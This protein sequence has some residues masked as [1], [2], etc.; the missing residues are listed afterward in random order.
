METWKDIPGFEGSYQVSDLGNVRSL[1]R[2]V[3]T[4]AHGVEAVRVMSG[5][6]LRS[7]DCRG[8]RIVN[9]AGKGTIAV[10]RLV[11]LAFLPNRNESVNHINGNKTDNRAINLEWLSLSDNQRHAVATGLKKQAKPVKSVSEYETKTYHSIAQ[12]ATSAGVAHRTIRKLVADGSKDVNGR[13][14]SAA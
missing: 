6:V 1:S 3:R 5:K 9:L 12:A 4:I 13:S 14:W 10:H 8:Y 2:Q 11:A 7:G